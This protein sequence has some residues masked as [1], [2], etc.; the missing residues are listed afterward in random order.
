MSRL[1]KKLKALDEDKLGYASLLDQC[2]ELK[3]E[4]YTYKLCFFNDAKQ[5]YTSLGRW[6]AFTGPKQAE[7]T[8]GQ[9]CPGGPARM[10]RVIFSCSSE[11]KVLE[12]NEPSRC[13]YEALVT[14]PGACDELDAAALEL[15]GAVS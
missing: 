2:L 11:M 15:A 3:D 7:F 4:Q 9:M 5:D 6:S 8:N 13:V 10:L 12:I 1:E 14:H